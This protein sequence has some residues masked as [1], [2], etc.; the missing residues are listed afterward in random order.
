M[1]T[2]YDSTVQD[3]ELLTENVTEYAKSRNSEA[4]DPRLKFLLDKLVDHLHN[5][6][7]ETR[8]T[9]KE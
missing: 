3:K 1:S 5:Y 4:S 8:L 2:T 7:R 9:N 6:V